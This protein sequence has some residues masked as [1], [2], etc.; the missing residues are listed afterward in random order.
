MEIINDYDAVK[1]NLTDK[2]YRLKT[3]IWLR[4]GYDIF[5]KKPELFIIYTLLMLLL[6]P[7][8]GFIIT[9]PLWAGFFLVSRRIDNGRP[10][11][12]ENFFDGFHFFLPLFL[13]TVATWIL[14][15]I[16][17]IF[18]IIPGIY[19]AVAYTFSTFFIIFGKMDFWDGMEMSRKIIGREWLSFF[20]FILTL[21]LVNFL[22]V[23]AFGIG[24]LFTI[25]ITSCAL[26]AA[27]DDI[28]GI[29]D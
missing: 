29:R 15:T 10:V 25:P 27:F 14:V 23:L 16:G 2:G 21:A 3:E 1:D 17:L 5:M 11:V 13:M 22:G 18:F 24:V 4:R 20:I 28:V 19:L 6:M 26:Y 8:G 12:L 7:M 9:G